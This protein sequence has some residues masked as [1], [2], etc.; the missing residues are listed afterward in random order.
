MDYENRWNYSLVAELQKTLSESNKRV[1]ELEEKIDKNK[2]L[3][4]AVIKSAGIL[5]SDEKQR[6]D[7]LEKRWSELKEEFQN[8]NQPFKVDLTRWD[9]LN[10]MK[11]LEKEFEE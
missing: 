5:F 3:H 1:D 10:V 6:A 2:R 4:D 8:T 11:K 7:E 9:V